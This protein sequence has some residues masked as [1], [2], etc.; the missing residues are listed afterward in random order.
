MVSPLPATPTFWD[1]FVLV[2]VIG[3]I[4]FALSNIKQSWNFPIFQDDLFWFLYSVKYLLYCPVSNR[5]EKKPNNHKKN[6]KQS[7]FHRIIRKAISG[8][9]PPHLPKNQKTKSV[10]QR[11]KLFLWYGTTSYRCPS[12]NWGRL[13]VCNFPFP[14][15]VRSYT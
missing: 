11:E 15:E 9:S 7:Q 13:I 14:S 2:P 6:K 8:A 12:W 4:S 5:V 1:D 10:P 3:K